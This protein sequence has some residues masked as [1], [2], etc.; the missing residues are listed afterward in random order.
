MPR[1]CTLIGLR[2]ALVLIAANRSQPPTARVRG[3]SAA[4]PV[5]RH[6]ADGKT[7]TRRPE[8]VNEQGKTRRTSGKQ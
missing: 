5:S 8:S 7:E 4:T 3:L 2:S 6:T 1:H